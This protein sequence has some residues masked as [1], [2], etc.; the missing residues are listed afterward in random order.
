MLSYCKSGKTT[1]HLFRASE[2]LSVVNDSHSK[3]ELSDLLGQVD[4][5]GSCIRGPCSGNAPCT[6]KHNAHVHSADCQ[7]TCEQTQSSQHH[8]GP[9]SPVKQTEVSAPVQRLNVHCCFRG[10]KRKL[11][12][13]IKIITFTKSSE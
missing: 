8:Y 4:S 13:V 10:K 5:P 3:R 2:K 1:I 6:D 11:L 7:K 12:C 9:I